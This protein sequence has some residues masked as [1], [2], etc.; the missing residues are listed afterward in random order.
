[1]RASSPSPAAVAYSWSG[2]PSTY[3]MAIQGRGTPPGPV[4][5]PASSTRAIPGWWRRPRISASSRNR[6]RT[7]GETAPAPAGPP[8]P[9]ELLARGR[10][11][12][13]RAELG[14][15]DDAHAAAPELA[16]EPPRAD[17][18]PRGG[19]ELGERVA[20][21]ERSV[22]HGVLLAVEEE[23]LQ[24]LALQRFVPGA[25]AGEE[26]RAPAPRNVEGVEEDLLHARVVRRRY[27]VRRPAHVSSSPTC[28][29]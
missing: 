3:S 12:I 8:A 15:V 7:S 16:H 11:A 29:A 1:M 18:A 14:Q 17:P 21:V 24:N 20:A 23:E 9:R 6:S 2:R 19:H 25:R 27:V 4:I 22:E 26:R 13:T 5:S 10:P 28:R